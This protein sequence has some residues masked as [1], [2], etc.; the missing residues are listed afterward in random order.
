MGRT[1]G[2]WE[3]A[4]QLLLGRK[5]S[6]FEA[7]AHRVPQQPGPRR[8]GGGRAPAAGPGGLPRGP[9]SA[10][11]EERPWPPA[12]LRASPLQL[13]SKGKLGDGPRPGPL[14]ARSHN[15]GQ[16]PTLPPAPPTAPPARRGRTEGA[17]PA[18]GPPPFPGAPRGRSPA[19][20]AG[21]RRR[22]APPGSPPPGRRGPGQGWQPPPRAAPLSGGG[23]ARRPALG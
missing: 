2:W 16:R 5:G 8:A 19:S 15:A 10:G 7:G 14:T 23:D 9:R 3:S 17:R 20:H 13:W 11:T 12:R 1:A 6:A 18:P 4:V 21:A 22:A